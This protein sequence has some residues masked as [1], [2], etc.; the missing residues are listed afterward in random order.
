MLVDTEAGIDPFAL[1]ARIEERSDKTRA[2]P[3]SALIENDYRL[4]LQMGG[5]LIGMM[6]V[7]GTIVAIIIVIF[8]A[9]AFVSVRSPELAVAKALGAPQ[10][11]LIMSAIVQTGAVALLGIIFAFAAILPLE[12][13]LLS[14]VPDVQVDFSAFTTLKLSAVMFVAAELAALVP[15]TYIWRVDPALVFKG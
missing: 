1:A 4:A 8:T 12:S 14:W 13:A 7:I 11:Q 3:K 6:S 2:L 5:A 10:S 15:V 9:Y